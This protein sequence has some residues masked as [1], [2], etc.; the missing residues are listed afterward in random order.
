MWCNVIYLSY[1]SSNVTVNLFFRICGEHFR[2]VECKTRWL[3]LRRTRS[4]SGLK[5]MMKTRLQERKIYS[6]TCQR[7]EEVMFAF[8]SYSYGRKYIFRNKKKNTQASLD[9][10]HTIFKSRNLK[11]YIFFSILIVFSLVFYSLSSQF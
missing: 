7:A 2:E 1:F 5:I 9:W 11:P 4:I 6:S 3:V 10:L 8:T